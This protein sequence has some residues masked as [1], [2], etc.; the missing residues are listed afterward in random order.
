MGPLFA[1][2]RFSQVNRHEKKI[3][4][5]EEE[6]CTGKKNFGVLRFS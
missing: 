3:M 5:M 1:V 6:G 2:N 4:R